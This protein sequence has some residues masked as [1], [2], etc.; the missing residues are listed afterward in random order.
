MAS[1]TLVHPIPAANLAP[2][3][4]RRPVFSTGHVAF[5][6]GSEFFLHDGFLCRARRSAPVGRNGIRP[7]ARR[8]APL[9]QA[10]AVLASLRAEFN[11][12]VEDGSLCATCNEEA[13]PCSCAQAAKPEPAPVSSWLV[14]FQDRAGFHADEVIRVLVQAANSE[15]ASHI[16]DHAAEMRGTKPGDI[17]SIEPW[18]GAS[19]YSLAVR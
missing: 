5:I 16:G 15:D 18:D 6:E 4:L 13:R 10:G 12:S 7:V 2:K 8:M 17:L 19:R 14:T 1:S 9:A 11:G 3:A